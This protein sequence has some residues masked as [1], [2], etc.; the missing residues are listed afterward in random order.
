MQQ[1]HYVVM[2]ISTK[3]EW[4]EVERNALIGILINVGTVDFKL[5]Q[6]ISQSSL[7]A[8][9]DQQSMVLGGKSLFHFGSQFKEM[10]RT[11]S[12]NQKCWY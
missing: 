1:H 5:K 10:R 4:D 3:P 8:F 12:K 2:N 6:T 11:V 9:Q 7:S